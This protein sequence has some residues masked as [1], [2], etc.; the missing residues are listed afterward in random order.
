LVAGFV[1][2]LVLAVFCVAAVETLG[3]PVM[4]DLLGRFVAYLLNV[5]AAA[6]V[7]LAGIIAGRVARAAGARAARAAGVAQSE[8]VAGLA[9]GTV[10]VVAVVI[11]IEQLGFSG[12]ALELV[13]ALVIGS[14]LLAAAL[15]FGLGARG[16]VSNMVAGHY[17]GQLLRV[18]QAIR[19]DEVAWIRP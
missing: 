19:I 3:L 4:T 9:H 5:L 16:T 17:V 11:A 2:W 7:M 1:F 12:R 13:V 18:G 14:G 6:L 10:V 15:A 8:A